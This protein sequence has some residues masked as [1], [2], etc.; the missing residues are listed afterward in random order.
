MTEP[1]P[2]EGPVCMTCSDQGVRVTVIAL[3]PDGTARVDT[4]AGEEE[5]SVALVDAAVGIAERWQ[6]SKIGE[7]LILDLRRAVFAHV[8]TMPVA[9]TPRLVLRVKRMSA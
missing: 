8:Q 4:G 1:L 2:C 3:H 7:G 5:V 6:S 9:F